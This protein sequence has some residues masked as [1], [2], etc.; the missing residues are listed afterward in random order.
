M[1]FRLSTSGIVFPDNDGNVRKHVDAK[2]GLA[3]ITGSVLLVHQLQDNRQQPKS[4]IDTQ[5][6]KRTT[7]C[8]DVWW[9]VCGLKYVC[10]CRWVHVRTRTCSHQTYR[11][12]TL[13][14]AYIVVFSKSLELVWSGVVLSRTRDVKEVASSLA[15][16]QEFLRKR[17]TQPENLTQ[18]QEETE[19]YINTLVW[20]LYSQEAQVTSCRSDATTHGKRHDII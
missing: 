12:Q 11:H 2:P 3:V 19:E 13:I 6:M 7:T 14:Y 20:C 17:A 15:P 10:N 18:L 5:T 9:H 1:L 16:R 4:Y 8:V